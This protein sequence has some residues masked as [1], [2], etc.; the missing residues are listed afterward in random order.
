MNS[1]SIQIRRIDSRASDA[2]G[3]LAALREAL[4][5]RGHIVSDEGRRRTKEVFGAELSPQEVVERICRDV[6]EKG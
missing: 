6:R 2:R 1:N 3:A 5:P 4:S